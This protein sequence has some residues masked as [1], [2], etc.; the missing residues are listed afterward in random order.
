V[1]E[2]LIVSRLLHFAAVIVVFGCGAFRLY[3]LA[4]H[5]TTT[6][7]NAL[8]TFDAWF[9]RVTIVGAIVALLSGLSLLLAVTANMAGSAAAALDPNTIGTVLFDTASGASGVGGCCSHCS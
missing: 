5:T 1:T 4:V 6:S 9:W 8:I 7:A 3:G 2:V